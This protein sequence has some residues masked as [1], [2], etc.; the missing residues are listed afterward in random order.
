MY[1]IKNKSSIKKRIIAYFLAILFSVVFIIMFLTISKTLR[2]L[3][4][5]QMNKAKTVTTNLAM[6]CA[7]SLMTISY[8]DIAMS[9]DIERL[10]A[11]LDGVKSSDVDVDY[12][13][14]LN[15]EGKCVSSTNK[16]MKDKYLNKTDFEKNILA[17]KDFQ[18]SKNTA[19]KNVFDAA[20]PAIAAGQKQGILRIGFSTKNISTKLRHDIIVVIVIGLL[21]SIAGIIIFFIMIQKG[22][23]KPLSEVMSV[24]QKVADGNL[25]QKE[26]KI[27]L[28][29]EIGEL[30]EIFNKMLRELGELVKL[31]EMIANGNVGAN[32]AEK[33]LSLG[34]SLDNAVSNE[35]GQIQGDL[36]S[37]FYKM[38]IELRKLTIQARKIAS[39]D[40]NNA[41]LNESISGELG[42]AFSLMTSNLKALAAIAEKIADNDL[43]VN[44]VVQSQKEVLANA[45]HKMITNLKNLVGILVKLSNNTYQ[46]ASGVAET[47]KQVTLTM[48]QVQNSL[49]QIASATAQV[50]KN[51]QEISALVHNTNRIVDTGNENINQV[52]NK[53]DTVQNTIVSTGQSINKL[54]ERSQEISEIVGLITKIADQ[55]NLLALNAAIEA[56]RAGEAG[57]GFAVVADE[58]RKLAESSGQSAEKISKIIKE[59]QQDM[60]T[61]V[62]SSKDSLV[63]SKIVLD[64]A[65]KMQ[66]GYNDIVEA[67]KAVSQQVE[68]ITAISEESAASAEEITAGLQEQ[69]A[70]I[71]EIADSSKALLTQV[72]D[73]KGE[74]KKF[75]V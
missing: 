8:G 46:S 42:E 66:R 47:T 1:S 63:E 51:T 10:D 68:E 25:S 65:G 41:V 35:N 3:N 67:I 16:E 56:A 62:K 22:I 38:Q 36:K 37:A 33:R 23:L 19:I 18:I 43:S 54:E 60:V 20:I 2:L 11:I 39:D 71:S 44:V 69:T 59:I 49:Q 53:F 27:E 52:I 34:I 6:V 32:E 72:N 75:R 12:V 55:T 30:A 48:S 21:S 24:A 15:Q 14:L 17:I 13:I 7:D 64:L 70:S 29:D 45:F 61:V 73:L 74:I 9:G 26:L 50:A 58:V 57:R 5:A 31:A 40:L 4:E 28:N